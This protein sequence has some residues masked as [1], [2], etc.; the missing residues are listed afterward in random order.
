MGRPQHMGSDTLW[1]LVIQNLT[2]FIANCLLNPPAIVSD[3][4]NSMAGE[5]L[6]CLCREVARAAFL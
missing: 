1:G 4:V 2:V 3:P 5:L 6:C